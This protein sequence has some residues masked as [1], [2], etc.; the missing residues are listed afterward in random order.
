MDYLTTFAKRIDNCI[1]AFEVD[2][3]LHT[4]TQITNKFF[5]IIL[6]AHI[7]MISTTAEGKFFCEQN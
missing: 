5:I 1:D 7:F 4:D 2:G 3:G 6:K